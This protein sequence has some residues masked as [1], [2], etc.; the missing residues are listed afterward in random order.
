[1]SFWRDLLSDVRR[2]MLMDDKVARME[3]RLD[4]TDAQLANHETRLVQIETVLF[5]PISPDRLKL[6]R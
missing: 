6:P 1:M 4:R 2:L 5:G 3:A